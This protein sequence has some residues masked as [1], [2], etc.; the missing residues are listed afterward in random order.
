VSVV[1]LGP[2]DA[3]RVYSADA[4]AGM[5]VVGGGE[6]ARR[7]R[8]AADETDSGYVFFLGAGCSR[9]SG[10]PTAGEL[11]ADNW[12]PRLKRLVA[13]EAEGDRWLLDEFPDWNSEEPAASY[14]DVI[15]RLFLTPDQRQREI[16]VLCDGKF[17]G[18]GYAVLAA[19][20]ARSG[21]GFNVA[22]TT[23]FDDLLADAMYLFTSA[24]PLV[25]HH[26]A[27]ASFI[28]PTRSRPLLVKLHGDNRLAPLNTDAETLG[29][30]QQLRRHVPGLLNDRGLI[31]VGYGG[32]DEGIAALLT[33]L[34]REA[35]PLGIYWV[36]RREPGGALRAWLDERNAAWVQEADF[37]ET[38]LLLH[39]TFEI[40]HPTEQRISS[41]FTRYRETYERLA[42]TI[43]A[44]P[45][46]DDETV[47]LKAAVKRA[48]DAAQ[49][50]WWRIALE[51]D[52]QRVADPEATERTFLAGIEEFP[53]SAELIGAYATYLTA[54]RERW[55]EARQMFERAVAVDPGNL[56]VLGSF[57][58][59]L[60]DSLWDLDA[61]EKTFER[62]LAADPEHVANLTNY[63]AFFIENREDPARAEDLFERALAVEPGY[64]RALATYA[65]FLATRDPDRAEALYMQA[66]AVAPTDAAVIARYA[67]FLAEHR[68]ELDRAE[69]AY[70]RAESVGPGNGRV[71]A[72]YAAFLA[73]ARSDVERAEE[74]FERAIS[75]DEGQSDAM[76]LYASFL[77]Q[78][79]GDKDRAEE[80]FERALGIDDQDATALRNYAAFLARR[81]DEQDRAEAMF[82]RAV[83]APGGQRGVGDYAAFLTLMRKDYDRAREMLNQAV[84][85]FPG[86]AHIRAN[87]AALLLGLGD[88]EAGQAVADEA[89]SLPGVAPPFRLGLAFDVYANGEPSRRGET[90]SQIGELLKR[91]VRSSGWDFSFHLA[92]AERQGD[93]DVAALRALADVVRGAS[94]VESLGG[95]PEYRA[96]DPSFGAR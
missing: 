70:E 39:K 15:E 20:M 88:R 17:P 57:G 40:A 46:G 64:L 66:I 34:P 44:R 91:G 3:D 36:S 19:L 14:G 63:A 33:S 67:A 38:M 59:F 27:L 84:A 53:N 85:D 79:R 28:R 83:A 13:P 25:I 69:A 77:D 6:F 60:A 76:V 41:V 96:I 86:D 56:Q 50:S 23:N 1:G 94:G 42:E 35:L 95:Y 51:A 81:M 68:H 55:P 24:R 2:R 12:L 37:D 52:R 8:D 58:V 65:D 30:D 11:V 29:I 4:M 21:G 43:V 49:G 45:S 9:S 87:Q 89:L 82:D 73:E 72:L 78:K 5:K 31:I 54:T 22:L 80:M 71:L 26:E 74:L 32:N 75:L 10:I 48:D 18:F 47:A 16:E 93:H 7:L 61:A 90:L 62:A 92:Q